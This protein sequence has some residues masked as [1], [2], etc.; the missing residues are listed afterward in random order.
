MSNEKRIN[1]KKR[2]GS[3]ILVFPAHS[4]HHNLTHYN[5]DRYC[6]RIRELGRDFDSIRICLYWKDILRGFHKVYQGFGFECVTAGHIYDP[7]FLPRLKSII[8]ISDLTLS[9]QIGTHVGYSVYMGKPHYLDNGNISYLGK[10][11]IPNPGNDYYNNTKHSDINEIQTGFSEFRYDISPEQIELIDKYWGVS[12]IKSSE[13]MK[14]ILNQVED[15]YKS[16]SNSYK[17]R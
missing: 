17:A 8:D 9:N 13:E 16:Y 10:S 1:E 6:L 4:T 7:M 14:T 11:E 2:L 3:N 5:I 15:Y 12:E